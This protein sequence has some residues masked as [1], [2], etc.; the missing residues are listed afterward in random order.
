MD[1]YGLVIQDDGTF[2]GDPVL[3]TQR[4]TRPETQPNVAA[5]GDHFVVTYRSPDSSGSG[6]FSTCPTV[7]GCFELFLDGF[8]SGDVAAWSNAVP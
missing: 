4:G 5:Q 3:L 2:V 1:L 6:I 8:E 7:L